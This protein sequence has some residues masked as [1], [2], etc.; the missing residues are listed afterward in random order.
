[1]FCISSVRVLR[2]SEEIVEALGVAAQQQHTSLERL[3][4]SR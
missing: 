4:A 2:A 3:T 1:M